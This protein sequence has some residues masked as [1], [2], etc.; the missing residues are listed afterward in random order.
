M[1]LP[2]RVLSICGIVTVFVLQAGTTSKFNLPT[3]SLHKPN[4]SNDQNASNH[5]VDHSVL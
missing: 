4:G 1:S 5:I 3:R 2:L